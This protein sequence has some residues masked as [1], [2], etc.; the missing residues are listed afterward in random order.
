MRH[1]TDGT[2][3]RLLDEP[4]GVTD[5]D[6]AHV[7]GCPD[8]LTT[9]AEVRRDAETTAAALGPD[10][11]PDLD[12]GW[13]RLSAAVAA[14]GHRAAAPTALRTPASP[15][16]PWRSRLGSPVAAGV[17][18]AVLLAGGGAAAATD[19]FEVFRTEQV[20]PLSISQADLVQIPDLSAYG[21]LEVVDSPE[22]DQAPDAA[23]AQ[24][25]TGL[26]VPQVDVLPRGVTGGPTY[27]VGTEAT[28]VFTFDADR[29]ART[30]A[31]AGEPLPAPPAGLDGARIRLSA[32]PGVAAVWQSG[33]GAPALLVGRAVAPTA[34]T[35]GV[36]F[37]T[38]RDYLLSMPG[39]SPE[40]ADQLRAFSED[41]TL[42][43]PV[44][45]GQVE[46][47]TTDVDG[48]T[49]TVLTDA[50]GLM[51]GVVWVEDGVMTAVAG[52][53]DTDE[54]LDVARALDGR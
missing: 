20:A 30:A 22:L 13:A 32:G 41:G 21:D 19:W 18:V 44:L 53:L 11:Q 37:A 31:D 29:A 50:D 35:S 40:L 33:S 7:A 34:E 52:T 39:M 4:A 15:S 26:D 43:I 3:R 1:P 36:D 38:A 9:L 54:V 51:S 25:A 23:A 16:R 6:R 5:A 14:D 28:A 46:S 8:C 49:A 47:E 48:S 2:L 17:G 12:A 42:P 45:S 10:A 24:Q 27:Q